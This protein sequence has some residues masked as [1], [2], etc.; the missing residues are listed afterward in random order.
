[1]VAL[2]DEA[3]IEPSDFRSEKLAR[4]LVE[5]ASHPFQDLSTESTVDLRVA[6]MAVQ[7]AMP[8]NTLFAFDGGRYL[9][10]V[11]LHLGD[12][13]PPIVYATDLGSIGLGMGLAIGAC[14]G[15]AGRPVLLVTG[16]G[17]FMLGGIAEFNTAVRNNLD[18]VVV[19]ANDDNYGAEHVQFRARDMDPSLSALHL[20]DL[21]P[22]AQALGGEGYTVRNR[23]DLSDVGEVIAARTKPLL[24]DLKLNPDHIPKLL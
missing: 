11:W 4:L 18:L 15:A 19:V 13:E 10:P 9:M 16:D 12:H 24:I 6:S 17:G 21:A 8:E 2:L 7:A 3:S 20:P 22:I 23:A 14:F 5:R 1:M